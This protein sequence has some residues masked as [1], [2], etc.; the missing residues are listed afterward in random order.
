MKNTSKH[1]LAAALLACLSGGAFAQAKNFEGLNVTGSLGYQS[2]KSSSSDFNDPLITTTEAAPSGTAVNVG[3][4]YITVLSQAAT[5]GFGLDTNVLSSNG[6]QSDTTSNGSI[7]NSNII[8]ITS[9]YS[10]SVMPGYAINND[11]LVYGKLSY[12][13]IAS[14]SERVGGASK[15][16]TGTGYGV[17][18]GFK[19]MMTRNLFVFGE[20]NVVAGVAKDGSDNG[21]TYKSKGSFTNIAVGV[22]YRF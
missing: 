3:V 9:S 20:G 13:Q 11:V 16:D 7:V 1:T 8:K 17:G 5:L 18:L 21:A 6:S 2:G 22:G 12:V 15:S 14:N 19:K 4:E 10:I